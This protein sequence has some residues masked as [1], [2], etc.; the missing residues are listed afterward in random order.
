MDKFSFKKVLLGVAVLGCS[1]YGINN[2]TTKGKNFFIEFEYSQGI[3][4]I[5]QIKGKIEDITSP[6]QHIQVYETEHFGNM[7]VI[8]DIIMLTQRDNFTYHEMIVHVPMNAHPNPKKVL[9]V[10]GGDGGTLNEV[11][12]YSLVEEVVMCEIDKEVINISK[13]YFPEFKAGFDDSRLTVIAQD[14][15]EYIKTKNKYF[16]VIIVDSTDPIGSGESLFTEVFYK[17]VHD[18]LKDDGITVTQ[19]ETLFYSPEFIVDIQKQNKKLFKH[20]AYYFTMVP[21]YP[22]G[23]IGFSF[24]SKKYDPFELVDGKKIASFADDL[25]YYNAAIHRASFQLPNFLKRAIES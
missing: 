20:S 9:I 17:N 15:A 25:K 14:A 6:Y 16:D 7:L 24:C 5:V 1:L 8:D 18:A 21:T 4:S 22:S 11:F 3:P 23:M 2:Y 13:K 12:R 19:S 10:G